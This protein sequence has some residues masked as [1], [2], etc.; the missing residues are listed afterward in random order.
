MKQRISIALLKQNKIKQKYCFSKVN[1]CFVHFVSKFKIEIDSERIFNFDTCPPDDS[2]VPSKLQSFAW[3][4]LLE[5]CNWIGEQ[6]RFDCCFQD[7][8]QCAV[9]DDVFC[10]TSLL[11]TSGSE[12]VALE[13]MLET[14]NTQTVSEPR[15]DPAFVRRG[16]Q[17]THCFILLCVYLH[18]PGATVSPLLHQPHDHQYFGLTP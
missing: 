18:A 11:P 5:T 8:A 14:H 7:P 12:N 9:L 16:F 1:L 10:Q 17:W 6:L 13:I 15:Q 4:N 2:I 3:R